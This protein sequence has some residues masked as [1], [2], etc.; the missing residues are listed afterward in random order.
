[1][2]RVI[3]AS[4]SPR[5]KELLESIGLVF[6]VV[7]AKYDE[8]MTG[9]I[10]PEKVVRTFSYEKAASLKADFPD[11]LIIAADTV[12][13]ID[14]TV[15][16]KPRDYEEAKQML[17]HL[18]G[19]SHTV[20]TGFTILDSATNKAITQVEHTQITL[21][22]LTDSQIE[23]YFKK[24][25]PLDKAGAYAIQGMGATFTKEIV[26]EYSNVVGLPLC[27]VTAALREFGIELL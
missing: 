17:A 26:G 22:P 7:P 15:Y 23:A 12:V 4:T 5:R 16:G 9:H 25:P 18:A 19:T 13:Y 1:M 11:A 27:S 20:Y 24:V 21:T 10:D 8:D 2:K 14:E 3:L 6:E